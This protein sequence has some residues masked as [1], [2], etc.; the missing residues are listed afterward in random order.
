MLS[1]HL[2]LRH[3]W[4]KLT[5]AVTH[6]QINMA[7]YYDPIQKYGDDKCISTL[8]VAIKAIDALLEMPHPIPQMVKGL[9]NLTELEND[10]FGSVLQS[11]LGKLTWPSEL[12]SGYWQAQNWDP[13]VSTEGFNIFCDALTS[14][15]AGGRIGLIKMY[16]SPS[17]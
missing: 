17:T 16:V 12:T 13:A 11:P 5:S 2:Q 1:C 9:F 7:E 3:L 6:A 10:D 15:R 4:R 14:G 8:Q